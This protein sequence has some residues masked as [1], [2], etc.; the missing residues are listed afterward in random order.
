VDFKKL[1]REDTP[2][3]HENNGFVVVDRGRIQPRRRRGVYSGGVAIDLSPDAE[4][5]RCAAN[6]EFLH[7]GR[8]ILAIKMLLRDTKNDSEW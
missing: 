6:L 8:L 7:F 2:Q 4:K 1:C 3:P 5:S